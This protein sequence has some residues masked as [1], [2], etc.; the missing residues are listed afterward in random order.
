M[1]AQIET[2]GRRLGSLNDWLVNGPDAARASSKVASSANWPRSGASAPT[3][4]SR[5]PTGR[6][7]GVD[8][9]GSLVAASGEDERSMRIDSST[10][11]A[12]SARAAHDGPG[13]TPTLIRTIVPSISRTH[14]VSV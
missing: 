1:S 10:A 6:I 3:P 11:A 8:T 7:G 12:T 13:H 5:P 14:K 4:H 2:P 9:L